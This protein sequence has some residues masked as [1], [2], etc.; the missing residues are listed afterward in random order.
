MRP[1]R[2]TIDEAAPSRTIDSQATFIAP[3]AS[4][5]VARSTSSVS[6]STSGSMAGELLSA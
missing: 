1:G 3:Y 6:G 2:T 5:S 4:G